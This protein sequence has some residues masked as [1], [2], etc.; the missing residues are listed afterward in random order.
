M[1]AIF[2]G[3]LVLYSQL[4]RLPATLVTLFIFGIW[5]SVVAKM[6]GRSAILWFIAGFFG[7]VV[8]LGMVLAVDSKRKTK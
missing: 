4:G 6:K 7:G 5:S 8:A 2:V 1:G 3:I